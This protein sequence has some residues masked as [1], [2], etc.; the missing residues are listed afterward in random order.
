MSLKPGHAISIGMDEAI[1][2]IQGH[3]SF[4]VVGHHHPD[5][6]AIGSVCALHNVIR[7]MGKEADMILADPVPEAYTTIE[8]AG[9]ITT[10]IPKGKTYD[11]LIFADLANIERAGDF[12]FPDVPSLCID[13][14][15]TNEGY[16]DFLYLKG[17]YAAAAEVVAEM[18][19]AMGISLDKDTC[20][21]LYMG[22]ATD[23]GFFKFSCTSAN[24]LLMAS[25]LVK[26]GAEPAYISAK[27]DEKTEEAMKCHQ[28]V[29]ETLKTYEKGQIAIACM[30]EKAMALDGEN[31]DSYASIPR[32]LKGV[33]IAGLFKYEGENSYRISLR[34][35][36]YANVA[37][38]A[39]EFGG[40]GHAR[41]AG[42]KMKGTFEDCRS[43]LVEAMARYL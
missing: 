30:D 28:R 32:C 33:E 29:V 23:S 39:G 11:A 25:Q 7:S 1:H 19:F 3:Q 27:I 8:A 15:E 5:G 34:S 17:E 14:H 26:L 21:A 36:R 12:D 22:I 13:H 38:L 40:G 10:E 4:L 41:A 6:D 42:C 35:V 24:T 43:R 16:A 2:F 31:A 9:K 37:K 20:N 18:L